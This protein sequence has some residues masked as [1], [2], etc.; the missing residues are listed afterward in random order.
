MQPESLPV[1][2]TD[3]DN[4]NNN[5]FEDEFD[6]EL[7]IADHESIVSGLNMI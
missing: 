7:Q 3:D 6:N 4:S 5:K 2:I 1:L